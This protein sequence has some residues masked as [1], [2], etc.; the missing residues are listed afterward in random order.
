MAHLVKSYKYRGREEIG[1]ILGN[2]LSKII[3]QTHWF[4]RIEGI[5]SVPTHWKHRVNRPLYAADKLAS[6]VSDSTGWPHL[7]ILKRTRAGPHQ[8]NLAFKERQQNVRGAFA[9]Q[10]GITMNGARLLLI[11]DVKTTGA[12]L[13]ECA[14]ILRKAGAAEIYAAVVVK[15]DW[16]GSNKLAK[17]SI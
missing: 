14:K 15:V 4:D 12:T 5:V 8:M 6:F 10:K 1:P 11:D 13:E 3:Q 17:S 2:W 9:M 7:K 16:T